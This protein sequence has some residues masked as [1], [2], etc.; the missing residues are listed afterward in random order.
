MRPR[1]I[2][3]LVFTFFAHA[4]SAPC[5]EG[6]AADY[7]ALLSPPVDARAF[8]KS[9]RVAL[10]E[11]FRRLRG[12]GREI[13]PIFAKLCA[14]PDPAN[15]LA[16]AFLKSAESGRVDCKFINLSPGG[17]K[18]R[19]SNPSNGLAQHLEQLTSAH[20]QVMALL[21]Q[22]E[23]TV[24]R[25]GELSRENKIFL[26]TLASF[27]GI[28]ESRGKGLLGAKL[29]ALRSWIVEERIKLGAIAEVAES[30]EARTF[31]GV[32]RKSNNK[33]DAPAKAFTASSQAAS[34]SSTYAISE[35]PAAATHSKASANSGGSRERDSEGNKG[36]NSPSSAAGQG[37]GQPAS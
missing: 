34:S 10:K 9:N 17:S 36:S 16:E 6:A 31:C 7:C 4:A 20:D 5:A 35:T 37:H 2:I 21:R 1:Q 11:A 8:A 29:G 25:D 32:V 14:E 13:D 27:P 12:L 23:R 24:A 30:L 19:L 33:W 18:R 28:G 26:G 22:E 3:I 15:A